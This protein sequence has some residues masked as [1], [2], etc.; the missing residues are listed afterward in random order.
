MASA[1]ISHL[2]LCNSG[3]VREYTLLI[4]TPHIIA[5]WSRLA[6]LIKVYNFRRHIGVAHVK[7]GLV[8]AFENVKCGL[9][10]AF[11]NVK[12]GLVPAVPVRTLVGVVETVLFV[13][14]LCPGLG[15][16]QMVETTHPN[17]AIIAHTVPMIT[18]WD[19]A[20]PIRHL[21][22]RHLF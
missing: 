8:P 6:V 19:F 7:C 9:V 1:K 10:P 22:I 13:H 11:E 15:H 5:A 17:G 12:C 2:D 3:R 14:E 4:A 21:L 20:L 16:V 18:T